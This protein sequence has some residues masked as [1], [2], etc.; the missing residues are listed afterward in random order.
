MVRKVDRN[1]SDAT[2]ETGDGNVESHSYRFQIEGEVPLDFTATRLDSI[3][4]AEALPGSELCFVW[5]HSLVD[6]GARPHLHVEAQFSLDLVRDFIGMLPGMNEIYCG[7]DSGHCLL[8]RS[9]RPQSLH[10]RIRESLPILLF[11]D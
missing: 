9:V 8:V 5:L 7:F 6:V 3:E 10:R 11:D 1:Q 4:V 2:G